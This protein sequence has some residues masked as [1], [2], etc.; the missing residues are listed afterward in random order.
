MHR[1]DIMTRPMLCRRSEAQGWGVGRRARGGIIF[2][3]SRPQLL[4]IMKSRGWRRPY[5]LSRLTGKDPI[6]IE[7]VGTAFSGTGRAF[8]PNSLTLGFMLLAGTVF[9]VHF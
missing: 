4:P 3:A 5:C 8:D 1:A 6:S 9:G 7:A 2:G